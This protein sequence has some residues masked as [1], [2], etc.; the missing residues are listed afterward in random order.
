M[1]NFTDTYTLANKSETGEA[2]GT[3]DQPSTL[4]F[5]IVVPLFA[6]CYGGSCIAFCTYKIYINCFTLKRIVKKA[7]PEPS[8]SSRRGSLLYD[9]IAD[10]EDENLLIP[11]RKPSILSS[12]KMYED[13]QQHKYFGAVSTHALKPDNKLSDL[14]FA[15]NNKIA[16]ENLSRGNP[17]AFPN[18][19]N[20]VRPSVPSFS[21]QQRVNSGGRNLNVYSTAPEN[22]QRNSF[23]NAKNFSTQK[24]PAPSGGYPN[25]D[26]YKAHNE[27]DQVMMKR[28][29]EKNRLKK[30]MQ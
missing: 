30:F 14:F 3:P 12:P 23:R 25:Q 16:P 21:D 26:A 7:I 18:D 1:H 11:P 19:I 6:A 13:N 27:F 5:Y 20:P 9:T 2:Q 15:K 4:V 22:N 29:A 17:L 28:Q 24:S 8:E 10:F